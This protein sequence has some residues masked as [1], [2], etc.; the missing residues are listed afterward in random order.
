MAMINPYQLAQSQLGL[1]E[2]LIKKEREQQEADM[3]TAGQMGSMEKKFNEQLRVATQKAEEELRRKQKKSKWGKLGKIVSMFAGPIAG[4]IISGLL[5]MNEMKRQS[6]YAEK[7]AK[8]AKAA[9]LGVDTSRF[10]GTFLGEKAKDYKA[11]QESAF[12]KMIAD[13]QV[14]T[15]DLLKSGLA[16]GL[17]SMAMGKVGD[18]IKGG[19]GDIKA[20]KG[21]E[22]AVGGEEALKELVKTA[23][24]PSNIGVKVEMPSAPTVDASGTFQ[25]P[26]IGEG[27]ASKIGFDPKMKVLDKSAHGVG[28]D[29]LGFEGASSLGV[30][31]APSNLFGEMDLQRK[32]DLSKLT[33]KLNPEQLK[34]LESLGGAEGVSKL[35]NQGY[36]KNIF[37]QMKSPTDMGLREGQT[38]FLQQLL[39]M[40]R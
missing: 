25:M 32:A 39:M 8:L 5:S 21:L 10:G 26:K 22:E 20:A 3:A 2:Q 30:Q 23:E 7:Q 9:A 4:P 36:L 17:T 18:K 40:F 16:S 35:A 11:Q 38:N 31:K 34:L 24:A 29:K 15:G 6:K 14:S 37:Q 12:D 13:T 1:S 28:L 33:N 19:I 27:A